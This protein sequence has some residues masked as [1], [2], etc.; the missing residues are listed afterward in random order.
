MTGYSAAAKLRPM[1]DALLIVGGEVPQRNALESRLPSFRAVCAADSGL[2]TAY[3]WGLYPDLIV[4]DMDSLTRPELL[5][6]FPKAKTVLASRLKDETDTEMGLR[7]L[8]EAGYRDI[9]VAGGG[10]G[11]L[12]HLLAVRSLFERIIRP[13]EW[14]TANERV[15]FVDDLFEVVLPE[16]TIVS[17]FPLAAGAWGMK[18]SGLR[19]PLEGLVWGPG[20]FGVSNE[21]IGVPVRIE[22]GV[23]DLL[24][25]LPI[26]GA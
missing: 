8:F 23:G 9:T 17:V 6:I 24:V 22:P 3:D 7:L 12:D 20:D 1:G 2:E 5:E 25:I 21:A 14:W 13:R 16:G 19:W 18:S 4:G 15:V 11:R 26:S 10:G